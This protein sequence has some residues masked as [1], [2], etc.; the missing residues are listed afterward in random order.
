MYVGPLLQCPFYRVPE[1]D[2]RHGSSIAFSGHSQSLLHPRFNF[3]YFKEEPRGALKSW[4]MKTSSV[5][6]LPF[7][8]TR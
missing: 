2:S 5:I 3:P 7:W 6:K 1:C 8:R 4:R